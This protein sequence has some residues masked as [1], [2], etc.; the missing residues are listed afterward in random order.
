M[1]CTLSSA[2]RK[3]KRMCD[4]SFKLHGTGNDGF[5]YIITVHNEVAKVMF[6]QVSV[7]PGGGGGIP[8]CLAGGI[9]ACLAAGL[10]GG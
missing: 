2:W 7:C 4:G 10:Q 8:A 5:I 3:S 9:P 6:L 1:N